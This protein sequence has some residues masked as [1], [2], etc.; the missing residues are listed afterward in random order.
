MRHSRL[1]PV[2][3]TSVVI[4]ACGGQSDASRLE[5]NKALVRQWLQDFDASYPSLDFID[6][7]MTPDFQTHINSPDAMDLAGYRQFLSD[8]AFSDIRHEIQYMIAEGDLVAAG[9]TLHM[10]HTGEYEGIAPTGRPVSIEEIVVVRLRE[11]KIAEEWAVV[12]FAA[13]QQ[14]LEAAAASP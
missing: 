6:E 3:L 2:A 12:D 5:D 7:W 10:T 11:G 9:I 13:L 14:Q 1:L 8:V 4:L